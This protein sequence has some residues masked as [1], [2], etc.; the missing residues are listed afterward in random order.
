MTHFMPGYNQIKKIR[1][2]NSEQI[3]RIRKREVQKRD[4]NIRKKEKEYFV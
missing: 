1:I 4:G 3:E 2:M